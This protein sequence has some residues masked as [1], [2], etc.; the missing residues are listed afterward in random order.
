M[1]NRFRVFTEL[2]NFKPNIKHPEPVETIWHVLLDDGQTVGFTNEQSIKFID[3]CTDHPQNF[4]VHDRLIVSEGGE[5][6]YY[7]DITIESILPVNVVLRPTPRTYKKGDM[8]HTMDIVLVNEHGDIKYN[9][10][11]NVIGKIE[12][13]L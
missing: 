6:D 11:F 2:S 8:Y 9:L 10:D 5:P 3:F 7:P 4:S 13:Q 12:E 1:E